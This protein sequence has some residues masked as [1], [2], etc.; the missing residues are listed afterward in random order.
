MAGAY[1]FTNTLQEKILCALWRDKNSYSTYKEVIQPRY[2]KSAVHNDICR[3]IFD[4]YEKYKQPPMLDNIVEEVD[5]L[6]KGS[7]IKEKLESEYIATL[8]NI[9]EY[10]LVDLPYIKDKVL[11]FGKRQAMTEA[12]IQSAEIIEK[13]GE[14]SKVDDLIKQAS[15]VGQNLDDMGDDYWENIEERIESYSGEEDV[16]VRITTGSGV[17]D[18]ILK[19]GLGKTEMGVAIS[20][21]GRGKTTFLIDKGAEAV[22]AGYN[23]V[24]YSFEN[25][26]KQVLR[27]Y[28]V[29]L[30]EK[31]YEY[32]QQNPSK[33]IQAL[34]MR[35]KTTQG[36]LIVQ[37]YPPKG[38]TVNTIRAHLNKLE[39]TKGFKPDMII[40]DYGALMRSTTG[41]KEKRD[42]YENIYLEI[43]ALADEY[44]C[45]LW[46]AAQANR[47]S[48]S[49][50]VISIDDLAECFAIANIA[51]FMLAL[52]QS[53]K[54]KIKQI[55]RY[56][57]AKNRDNKDYMTLIGKDLRDIKKLTVD[58]EVADEDD[59]DDDGGDLED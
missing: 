41:Y 13:G 29:R 2:F 16:I 54:E 31:P 50:K 26:K 40:I 27:N 55:M 58:G 53:K 52:C 18:G 19:G 47:G 9:S 8:T 36:T 46:T 7:K 33:V 42:E 24:H 23:V 39:V 49:K 48:L 17:L 21:P 51:D 43:G 57:V 22:K 38:A 45:A 35:R 59:E 20:P 11:E 56:F 10:D 5:Q 3:I 32:L 4:Y 15:L 12:I 34:R 6:M 25:N 37:K 28:D 44:D 30:T 1:E 14:F